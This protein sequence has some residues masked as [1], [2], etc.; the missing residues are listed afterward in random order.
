MFYRHCRALRS[1]TADRIRRRTCRVVRFKTSFGPVE[2]RRNVVVAG[3]WLARAAVADRYCSLATVA[4]VDRPCSGIPGL[5]HGR[6]AKP[7]ALLRPTLPQGCLH[8]LPIK[9]KQTLTRPDHQPSVGKPRP[10]SLG[11]VGYRTRVG[12]TPS[13]YW[14]TGQSWHPSPLRA[15]NRPAK[16]GGSSKASASVKM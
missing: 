1:H 5:R 4:T 12:G 15:G 2:P 8:R 13:G 9:P 10:L 16:Q 14:P 11:S 7:M 3:T 6:N